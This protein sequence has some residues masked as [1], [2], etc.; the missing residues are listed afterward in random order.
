MI[1]TEYYTLSNIKDAINY[2][3]KKQS[4]VNQKDPKTILLDDRMFKMVNKS[5]I[6][7][8]FDRIISR[9][10]I[11]DAIVTNNFNEYY[12]IFDKNGTPLFKTPKRGSIPHINIVTEMKIGRK[13]VTRINNFEMYNIDPDT[14]AADLR[15]LCSGSTTISETTQFG[16]EVQIQGSHGLTIIQYLNDKVGIPNKW[17][18]FENKLKNK[19]KRK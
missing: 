8:K 9:S 18:E 5:V 4:L 19:N 6:S 13:V 17:V 10:Q 1:R 11:M 14:I 2:Y 16:A 12:K 15:K 7:P 3:I